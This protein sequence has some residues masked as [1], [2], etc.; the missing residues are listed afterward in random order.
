MKLGQSEH[1]LPQ[2]RRLGVRLPVPPR[3]LRRV[4]QPEV[5][6]HVD[7]ADPRVQPTPHLLGAHA[8]GQATEYDIEAVGRW[9][10]NELP[11]DVEQGK[12]LGVLLAG[13]AASRHR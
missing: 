3:V 6:A 8:V 10:R 4:M 13:V 5:G 7:H 12:H 2:Q 11:L 9:L 1:G